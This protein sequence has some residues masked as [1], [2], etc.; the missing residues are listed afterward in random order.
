MYPP[1]VYHLP[2]GYAQFNT[3]TEA[4]ITLKLKAGK[5]YVFK[6]ESMRHSDLSHSTQNLLGQA[7]TISRTCVYWQLCLP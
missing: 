4:M 1:L 3:Y 5:L 2:I 6:D 7:V